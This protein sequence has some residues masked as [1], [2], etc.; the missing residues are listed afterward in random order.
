MPL[1]RK[2]CLALKGPLVFGKE[3]VTIVA[4]A[5]MAA[6]IGSECPSIQ[7]GSASQ[8]PGAAQYASISPQAAPRANKSSKA[9]GKYTVWVFKLV[10]RE[11][12]KQ[13]DRTLQTDDEGKGRAYLDRVKSVSGWTATSNLPSKKK[14]DKSD[15][16][17]TAALEGT[18][19]AYFG[20]IEGCV[21]SFERGGGFWGT[22]YQEAG[23]WAQER[24]KVTMQIPYGN[25]AGFNVFT[26]VLGSRDIHCVVKSSPNP[27]NV[28]VE[29]VLL[30]LPLS[31]FSR[32]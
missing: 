5:L 4:I 6:W 23:T 24:N 29:F 11:W 7:A 20:S 31:G 21:F 10:N 22:S 8:K 9:T 2:P 12:Q 1:C 32:D 14:A 30:R 19:W 3:L 25:G 28:G 27:Q 15:Q 16:G 13:E 26:G 17:T 18:A